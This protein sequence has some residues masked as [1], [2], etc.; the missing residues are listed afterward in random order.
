MTVQMANAL[1]RLAAG[2]TSFE[3]WQEWRDEFADE[4]YLPQ[5][6]KSREYGFDDEGEST[7]YWTWP[8][9]GECENRSVV[10]AMYFLEDLF[11]H[12]SPELVACLKGTP[13]GLTWLSRL[14]GLVKELMS[15]RR[16]FDQDRIV[17]ELRPFC[18]FFRAI[19]TTC[20]ASR[21]EPPRPRITWSL[22]WQCIEGKFNSAGE[23]VAG[24]SETV[25]SWRRGSKKGGPFPQDMY[26]DDVRRWVSDTHMYDIGPPPRESTGGAIP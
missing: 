6:L 9:N 12:D 15:E 21:G 25:R 18:F 1:E 24:S 11:E 26:W 23:P 4:N 5:A 10:Y 20:S 16:S 3:D 17:K 14:Y 22:L 7:V 8:Y 2:L 13:E 19:S